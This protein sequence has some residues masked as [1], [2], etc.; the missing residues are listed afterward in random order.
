MRFSVDHARYLKEKHSSIAEE[1]TTLRK[2]I[3]TMKRKLAEVESDLDEINSLLRRNKRFVFSS[4]V[5]LENDFDEKA[6]QLY[7]STSLNEKRFIFNHI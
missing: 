7:F 6:T 5:I 2:G 1:A 4:K 3:A